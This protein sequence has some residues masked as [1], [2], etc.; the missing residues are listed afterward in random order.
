MKA[1]KYMLPILLLGFMIGI[2]EGKIAIWHGE[3]PMPCYILPYKANLLPPSE[4]TA[5]A[6]GIRID[7]EEDLLHLIEDFCS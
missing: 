1:K 3:D 5:L 2:H 7:S 4:R 6:K